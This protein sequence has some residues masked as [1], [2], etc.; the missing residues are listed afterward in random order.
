MRYPTR[1]AD[2][3]QALAIIGEGTAH[4]IQSCM[5]TPES[6]MRISGFCR[7]SD[8]IEP[9]GKKGDHRLWRIKK[10]GKEV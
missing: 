4:Q 6:P 8:R 1:L 7:W 9:A 3:E 2:V 5:K 10:R